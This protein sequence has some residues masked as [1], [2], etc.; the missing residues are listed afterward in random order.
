MRGSPRGWLAGSTVVLVRNAA[1]LSRLRLPGEM[2][3]IDD[4][5]AGR[6]HVTVEDDDGRTSMWILESAR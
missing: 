3:S 6:P 1:I 4:L 2:V 5:L